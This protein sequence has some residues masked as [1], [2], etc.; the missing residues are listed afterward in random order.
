[1]QRAH[2]V[3]MLQPYHDL[4]LFKH[5]GQL[6]WAAAHDLD[7]DII[8]VPLAP[9]HPAAAAAAAAA[10]ITGVPLAPVHPAAAAAA[11]AASLECHLP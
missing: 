8:I 10:D 4:C 3:F 9:V 2:N 7:G 5:P 6:Y 11:A 1:M